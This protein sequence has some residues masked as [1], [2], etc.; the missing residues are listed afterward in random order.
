MGKNYSSA[1]NANILEL[2]SLGSFPG[3]PIQKKAVASKKLLRRAVGSNLD[4]GPS[5]ILKTYEIIRKPKLI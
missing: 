2:H 3:D 1:M 5:T 4:L